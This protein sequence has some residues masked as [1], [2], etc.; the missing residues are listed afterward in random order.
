MQYHFPWDKRFFFKCL[1]LHI[2]K[3]NLFLD[4]KRNK[5]LLDNKSWE[6]ID[7]TVN[8]MDQWPWGYVWLHKCGTCFLKNQKRQNKIIYTNLTENLFVKKKWYKII[9]ISI[10]ESTENV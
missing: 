3:I 8:C 7:T 9:N 2:S 4:L 1:T 5:R 6:V 10:A